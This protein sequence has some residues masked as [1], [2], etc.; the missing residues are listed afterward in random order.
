[1]NGKVAAILSSSA[2]P[3]QFDGGG[4]GCRARG[5][6]LP[7]HSKAHSSTSTGIPT[8]SSVSPSAITFCPKST[9]SGALRNFASAQ[10]LLVEGLVAG[11][12]VDGGEH[13]ALAGL[14]DAEDGPPMRMRFQPSSAKAS[15][16]DD[17]IGPETSHRQ[18][19]AEARRQRVERGLA[20]QQQRIAI[21]K[22]KGDVGCRF[23]PGARWLRRS[24]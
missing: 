20:D 5:G 2:R 11:V 3:A 15:A 24:T 1:L 13:A 23:L 9:P 21:G 16:P 19:P 10:R 17:Q 22:G 18:R 12:G 6:A 8:T 14:G 7:V 4:A